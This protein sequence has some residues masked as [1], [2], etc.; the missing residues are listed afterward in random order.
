MY[1]IHTTQLE[2]QIIRNQEKIKSGYQESFYSFPEC[3]NQYRVFHIN[4]DVYADNDTKVDITIK[5]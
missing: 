5:M 2:V 4:R 1:K 3:F